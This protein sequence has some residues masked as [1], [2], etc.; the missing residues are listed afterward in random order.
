MKLRSRHPATNSKYPPPPTP[1]LAPEA[2]RTANI[3]IGSSNTTRITVTSL[4][5]LVTMNQ[6]LQLRPAQH[7]VTSCLRQP[8][9]A[10]SVTL[11]SQYLLQP[12]RVYIT[13]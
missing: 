12:S 1:I 11:L 6:L 10:V 9:V 4:S 5:L 8:R 13:L 2:D 7:H 3:K